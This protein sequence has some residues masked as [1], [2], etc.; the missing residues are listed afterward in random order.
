M[1]L[2]EINFIPIEIVARRTLLRHLLFWTGCLL[3]SLSLIWGFY[4]YHQHTLQAKK[5]SVTALKQMH[6]NLGAKIEEIKKIREEV[7]RL[8]QK[9]AGL[10]S[11]TRNE[12]YSRIFAELADIMNK[13]TWLSQLVID[14]GLGEEAETSLRLVGFSFSAE[15]LGNFLNQLSNETSFKNVV[16]QRAIES[17]TS[18]LYKDM[19]QPIRLIQFQIVCSVPRV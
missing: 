4:F 18:G 3:I 13:D 8:R 11:I 10:E 2:R 1:A 15:E 9:Q 14:S 17:E 16:L 5:R 12:S 7:E 19:G 6:A